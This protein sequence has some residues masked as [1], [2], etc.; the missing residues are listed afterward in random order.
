MRVGTV[1][2]DFRIPGSGSLKEKRKVVASLKDRVRKR[3][4]VAI[5]EVGHQDLYARGLLGVAAVG[6]TGGPIGRA[7]DEILRLVESDPRIL[8]V[9]VL[10]D[11]W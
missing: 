11:D 7:L 3:F 6:E 2:I 10:R 5:A 4:P 1:E 9:D 8:I